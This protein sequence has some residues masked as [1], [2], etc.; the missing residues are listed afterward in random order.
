MARLE[1]IHQALAVARAAGAQEIAV[2]HC[3][4]GYPTPSAEMNLRALSTLADELDVV[5]GLSDHSLGRLAPIAAVALGACFFEKHLTLARTDGGPDAGFS[6]GA[7]RVLR[8]GPGCPYCLA[9]AGATAA[10]NPAPSKT[11]ALRCVDPCMSYRTSGKARSSAEIICAAS[12][13]LWDFPPRHLGEVL[14]KPASRAVKR[15]EPLQWDLVG[16]G[17]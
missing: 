11:A 3:V 16:P 4:S 5:L 14:G 8:P 7:R 12:G 6:P 1:E 2:L 17:E 9:G 10:W 15:G 13:R